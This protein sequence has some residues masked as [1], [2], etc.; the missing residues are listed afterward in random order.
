MLV[1]VVLM[2][3]SGMECFASDKIQTN[4]KR[5]ISYLQCTEER[6]IRD[7]SRL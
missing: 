2:R 3:V 4:L 5:F 1:V 7:I 6:M